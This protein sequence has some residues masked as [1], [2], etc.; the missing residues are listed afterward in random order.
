MPKGKVSAEEL[1]LR[2]SETARLLIRRRSYTE[3]ERELSNR[4]S[5]DARTT[6]RWIRKVKDRW[7]AEADVEGAGDARADLVQQLDAVLASAWS[8]MVIVKDADGNPVVDQNPSSPGFG[9][10]LVRNEPKTQQ[11]LHAISQLRALKGADRPIQAKITLDG[12]INLMPDVSVLPDE[13]A[14]QLRKALEAVAPD[15]D[16]RKLAGEWMRQPDT[17]K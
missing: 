10:P 16:L 12:D 1:E 7:R 4:Y 9:K 6:R 8:H 2:L 13:V 5:V 11:I 17:G 14:A 3:V 15:G